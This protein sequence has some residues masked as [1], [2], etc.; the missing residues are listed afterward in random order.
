MTKPGSGSAKRS[1]ILPWSAEISVP[2]TDFAASHT[3]H[4]EGMKTTQKCRRG[5]PAGAL[6]ITAALLGLVTTSCG[7]DDSASASGDRPTITISA[8]DTELTMPSEVPSG[9]VDVELVTKGSTIGHHLLIGR[10]NDGVTLEEVNNAEDSEFFDL[11]SIKGGNGTIEAG[12]TASMIFDFEPGNYFVY[13]NPQNPDTPTKEFT[14]VESARSDVEPKTK[15]TVTMGPGMLISV[16]DDFDGRGTWQF[17]NK[18]ATLTHETALVRLAEGATAADVVEW[19]QTFEGPP[20]FAG[21][22][23]GMGAL[24]PGEQGWMRLEPGEPG[25]YALICFIPGPDGIPH[26]KTGMATTVKIGA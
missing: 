8:S 10:L 1:P 4:D 6:T 13:D 11:V 20:P 23:G 25:D 2:I 9:L 21:E 26:V 14:V 16:P 3:A 5:R 15:G 7:S 24:G 17:V 12:K 22:F 18:D 19:A